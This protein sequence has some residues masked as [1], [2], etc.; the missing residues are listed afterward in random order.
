M[1]RGAW[2]ATVHGVAKSW[3]GN[4]SLS[5]ELRASALGPGL[6]PREVT[7]AAA[8]GSSLGPVVLRGQVGLLKPGETCRSAPTV[9][10][11]QG[12]HPTIRPGSPAPAPHPPAEELRRLRHAGAAPGDQNTH[13]SSPWKPLPP[14]V[15]GTDSKLTLPQ[16]LAVLA[17]SPAEFLHSSPSGLQNRTLWG[18]LL[19]M[20]DT[21][22][23]EPQQGAQ[24][25]PVRE[26]L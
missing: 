7:G 16:D 5:R 11:P 3:Q 21:Q 4:Q 12:E 26:C 25:S 9:A 18:F 23:G 22:G 14:T 1:D 15:L 10:T 17:P 24:K 20:P 13:H 2:W 8:E 6:E 19:L